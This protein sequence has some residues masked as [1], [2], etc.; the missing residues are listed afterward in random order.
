MHVIKKERSPLKVVL[1]LIFLLEMQI[2]ALA[3]HK[4]L[5][6]GRNEQLWYET[7]RKN[8]PI[9]SYSHVQCP[10]Q[11][12]LFPSFG[13]VNSG[14]KNSLQLSLYSPLSCGNSLC[15]N[16]PS[17]TVNLNTSFSPQ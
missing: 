4:S 17:E 14:T 11:V 10:R 3:A 13:C 7:H 9:L 1:V 15:T 8:V 6:V 5:V 12:H 2:I 16:N